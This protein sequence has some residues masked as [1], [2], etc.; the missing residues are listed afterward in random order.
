MQTYLKMVAS[1]GES[2]AISSQEGNLVRCNV[3]SETKPKFYMCA[4]EG[5]RVSIFQKD[6]KDGIFFLSSFF[7]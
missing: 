7:L 1:L 2:A 4:R 5:R 3:E 6:V